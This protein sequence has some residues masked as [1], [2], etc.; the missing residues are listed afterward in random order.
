MPGTPDA[1]EF[2]RPDLIITSERSNMV[3]IH[4]GLNQ[5]PIHEV[6]EKEIELVED[7]FYHLATGS[8]VNH[9]FPCILTQIIEFRTYDYDY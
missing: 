7:R 5:P 1:K 6:F 9:F 4:T 8:T 3:L 2:N